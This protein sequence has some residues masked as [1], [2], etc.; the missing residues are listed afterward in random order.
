MPINKLMRAPIRVLARNKL[1]VFLF[2]K[3][4]HYPDPL[5][6][7][8]MDLASFEHIL[9]DVINSFRVISMDDA[10]TGLLSDKLPPGAAC[11]TFDDG[12]SDWN[13]GVVPALERRNMHATFYITT[14]QFNGNPL[15]HERIANVVRNSKAE[16]LDLEHVA[17]KP[18]SIL[19]HEQRISALVTLERFLKYFSLEKRNQLLAKLE[20]NEGDNLKPVTCM[21]IDE[22]RSI[23]NRGFGIGAHTN[24]HPILNYCDEASARYEIGAS[25]EI[26]SGY[27][28]APIHSF[29]YPN[30]RPFSD[31]SSK[32]VEIVKQ[33]GFKSAVTT[34]KGIGRDQTSVFQIPRFT[35]WGKGPFINSLQLMRNL[36]TEAN[37]V[38]E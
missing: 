14:G 33:A 3:V 6:P 37:Y 36:L 26:L 20:G 15:W 18:M 1:S 19:T 21:S 2:H 32:H 38:E 29:A 4:P 35:P 25:R 11:I 10:V 16:F 28:G 23:H 22:L 5:V 8:D 24:G 31:Y 34:Q 12:Y 9:D 7:M 13:K 27:I 30:G 17:L